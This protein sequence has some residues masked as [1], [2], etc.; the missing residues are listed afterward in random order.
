M[1]VMLR[2]DVK[3]EWRERMIYKDNDIWDLEHDERSLVFNFNQSFRIDEF[4]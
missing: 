1:K 4:P 3:E 2:K